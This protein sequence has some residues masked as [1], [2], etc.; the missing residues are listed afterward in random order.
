MRDE[1]REQRDGAEMKEEGRETEWEMK[2]ESR[3]KEWEMSFAFDESCVELTKLPH[4]QG[5]RW[6]KCE[7]EWSEYWGR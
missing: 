5:V 6:V 3:E 7:K 1:G 4:G 2:E